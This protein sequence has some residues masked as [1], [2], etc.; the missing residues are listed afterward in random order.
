MVP[1]PNPCIELRLNCFATLRRCKVVYVEPIKRDV[2][3]IDAAPV[4]A[5]VSVTPGC[6]VKSAVGS[7]LCLHGKVVER[8]YIESIAYVCTRGVDGHFGVRGRDFNLFLRC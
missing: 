7:F 8:V 1:V 5:P 6:I 2:I 3:L 4:T